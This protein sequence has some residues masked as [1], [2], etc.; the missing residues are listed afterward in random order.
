[1]E[2]SRMKDDIEIGRLIFEQIPNHLRPG[3]AGHI[4]SRFDNFIKDVPKEIRE[5]LSLINDQQN[6]KDAQKQFS[7]IRQFLLTHKSFQP[8]GYLLLA[9]NVAKVTYNASGQLCPFDSDS[10][11]WIPNCALHATNYFKDPALE[12][13]VKSAILFYSRNESEMI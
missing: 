10:G 5:L 12:E 1:M 9:E 11:W 13:D 7:K 3:W 8:E 2:T 4:L 6:W